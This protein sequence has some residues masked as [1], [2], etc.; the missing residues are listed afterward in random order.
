MM[1]NDNDNDNDNQLTINQVVNNKQKIG[2]PKITRNYS[3]AML[4]KLY[5]NYKSV[6]A[7]AIVLKVTKTT[8]YRLFKEAGIDINNLNK[9]HISN[10]K[11]V[12][13]G[14][15]LRGPVANYIRDNNITHIPTS[16]TKLA[17][18]VGCNVNTATTFL[19]R[20]RKAITEQLASLP[21]FRRISLLFKTI[22]GIETYSDT[23]TDYKYRVSKQ[24][25][26]TYIQASVQGS[27][28]VVPLPS[29]PVFRV[30]LEQLFASLEQSQLDY[31]LSARK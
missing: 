3:A 26:N 17:R 21:D 31:L 30:H 24:S 8:M 4:L 11:E 6:R 2:R 20:Q 27:E 23:W 9:G 29:L 1:N 13:I 14:K 22:D 25:F 15:H 19:Y 16:P 5:L 7:C 18:M 28:V 12:L 10:V